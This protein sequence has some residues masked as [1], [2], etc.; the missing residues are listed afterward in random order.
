MNVEK[1]TGKTYERLKSKDLARAG[2]KLAVQIDLT[3]IENGVFYIEI[4]NGVL[5]VMPYEY[6]DRD[7]LI[8]TTEKTFSGIADG[9]LNPLMAYAE[10]KLKVQGNVDKVLLLADL[11]K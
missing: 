10:G 4:K 11:L 3:D 8:R 1:L 2:E 9:R 7:A 6:H 5:S